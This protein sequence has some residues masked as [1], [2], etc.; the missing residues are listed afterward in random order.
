MEKR[1]DCLWK[2]TE[3]EEEKEDWREGEMDEQERREDEDDG[4]R[5]KEG[6]EKWK[7]KIKKCRLS[8]SG[9]GNFKEGLLCLHSFLSLSFCSLYHQSLFVL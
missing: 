5:G 1:R 3:G 2:R 7:K 4:G 8:R 6:R 9:F